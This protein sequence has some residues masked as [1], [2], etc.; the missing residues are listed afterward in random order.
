MSSL[1]ARAKPVL[2]SESRISARRGAIFPIEIVTII[3]Y[4]AIDSFNYEHFTPDMEAIL[5]EEARTIRAASQVCQ[6]WRAL[7]FACHSIWGTIL[8][9]DSSSTVWIMELLRRS[10]TAPLTIHSTPSNSATT[11]RFH[12]QKWKLLLAQTHRFRKLDVTFGSRDLQGVSLIFRQPAPLLES[13]TLKYAQEHAPYLSVDMS[14]SVPNGLFTGI[15]PKLRTVSLQKLLFRWSPDHNVAQN[16]VRLDLL[17]SQTNMAFFTL[18][19]PIATKMVLPNLQELVVTG[20]GGCSRF[21]S[22]LSIPSSCMTTLFFTHDDPDLPMSDDPL[23][24][25]E[26][27]L[28]GWQIREPPIYS[29]SLSTS[30]NGSFAFHAGTQRNSLDRPQ[31]VLEYDGGNIYTS[32]IRLLHFV[33]EFLLRDSLLHQSAA[34]K[35]DFQ[36][37]LYFTAPLSENLAAL[38]SRCPRLQTLTILGRSI[39]NVMA[40]LLTKYPEATAHLRHLILDGPYPASLSSLLSVT[41]L[42]V[43]FALQPLKNGRDK[44]QKVTVCVDDSRKYKCLR[45]GISEVAGVVSYVPLQPRVV[46]RGELTTRGSWSL[47]A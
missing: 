4:M 11:G 23:L 12:S 15:C 30:P 28:R 37:S 10:G 1:P 20:T 27:Y 36:A 9:V 32:G 25:V 43:Q 22:F 2:I 44:L 31:F 24:W 13:L 29:W 41:T 26:G 33:L 6:L 45:K 34:M 40:P 46:R 38:L 21:L 5:L 42:L 16:I 39:E 19:V 47:G 18:G 8:N 3:F 35:L 7:S 17:L 14:F